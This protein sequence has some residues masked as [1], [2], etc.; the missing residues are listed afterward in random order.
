MNDQHLCFHSY[1]QV[2]PSHLARPVLTQ[3]GA[4]DADRKER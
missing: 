3:A 4:Y 1:P 2:S